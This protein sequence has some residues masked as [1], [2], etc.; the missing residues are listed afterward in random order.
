MGHLTFLETALNFVLLHETF[1]TSSR[2]QE[3]QRLTI[4]SLKS[5]ELRLGIYGKRAKT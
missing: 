2:Y 4:F 5:L 3:A 1:M